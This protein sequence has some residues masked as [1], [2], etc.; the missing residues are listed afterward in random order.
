[1]EPLAIDLFCGLGGWTSGLIA[2]DYYVVE[3]L[4]KEALAYFE[5]FV[6]RED[7]M[8]EGG[9]T[10]EQSGISMDASVCQSHNPVK[11]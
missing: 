3:T 8:R 2:E 5:K 9:H 10:V 1:M 7:V 11:I 6:P 4:P